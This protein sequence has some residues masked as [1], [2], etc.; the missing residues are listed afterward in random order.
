MGSAI[1]ANAIYHWYLVLY[2]E[3]NNKWIKFYLQFRPFRAG[4]PLSE[5]A[6]ATDKK[7]YRVIHK[8]DPGDSNLDKV[9][10]DF[11]INN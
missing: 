5:V 3:M 9:E 4:L 11:Y 8:M 10:I 7:F 6:H 1:Y 2:Q